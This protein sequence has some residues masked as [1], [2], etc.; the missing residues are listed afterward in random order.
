MPVLPL[1]GLP[2]LRPLASEG[3][4]F[5]LGLLGMPDLLE[6][7]GWFGETFAFGPWAQGLGWLLLFLTWLLLPTGWFPAKFVEVLDERSKEVGV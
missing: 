2:S 1:H 4:F 6:G 7:S 5:P 3:A